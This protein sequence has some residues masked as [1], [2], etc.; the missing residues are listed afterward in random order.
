MT[1]KRRNQVVATKK[2]SEILKPTMKIIKK[3]IAKELRI[4]L[5][6]RLRIISFYQKPF[7]L[8]LLFSFLFTTA[9]NQ[10]S[11]SF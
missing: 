6:F 3:I 5:L 1:K 4:G 8:S 2:V 7:K 9:H 11:V 10:F